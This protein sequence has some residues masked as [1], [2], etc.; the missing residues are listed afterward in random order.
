MHGFQNFIEKFFNHPLTY[1][2]RIFGKS[3]F[4]LN[5]HSIYPFPIFVKIFEN[6][7][8]YQ[9]Q[10]VE[11]GTVQI[12]VYHCGMNS[13]HSI[14]NLK[15]RIQNGYLYTVTTLDNTVTFLGPISTRKYYDEMIEKGDTPQDVISTISQHREEGSIKLTDLIPTTH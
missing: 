11:L 15:D 14:E 8:C 6:H 3:F 5:C 4:F 2:F 9:L 12:N 13:T 1:L 7:A 10:C